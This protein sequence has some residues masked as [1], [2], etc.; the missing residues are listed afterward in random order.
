MEENKGERGMTKIHRGRVHG[1]DTERHGGE[2]R[3]TTTGGW[4]HIQRVKQVGDFTCTIH[5]F[6]IPFV[7]SSYT[8]YIHLICV[9]HTRFIHTYTRYTYIHICEGENGGKTCMK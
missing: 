3:N 1:L 6:Y 5:T 9:I 7:Y 2:D 4:G 8:V